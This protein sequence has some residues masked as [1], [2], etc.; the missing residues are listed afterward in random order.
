M[1]YLSVRAR[2]GEVRRVAIAPTWLPR[3]EFIRIAIWNIRN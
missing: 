2:I 3:R 1:V